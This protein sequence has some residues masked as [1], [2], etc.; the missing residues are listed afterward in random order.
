[1]CPG[2][3]VSISNKISKL[4]ETVKILQSKNLYLQE[5]NQRVKLINEGLSV[6]SPAPNVS[7]NVSPIT[8]NCSS[9]SSSETSARV[10]ILENENI[11]NKI[12]IVE[13]NFGNQLQLLK[14][15]FEKKLSDIENKP[16]QNFQPSHKTNQDLKVLSTKHDAL[17]NRMR[18]LENT[19][20]EDVR[21]KIDHYLEEKDLEDQQKPKNTFKIPFT[22]AQNQVPNLPHQTPLSLHRSFSDEFES[23]SSPDVSIIEVLHNKSEDVQPPGNQRKQDDYIHPSGILQTDFTKPPPGYSLF[24]AQFSEEL[25]SDETSNI[26]TNLDEETVIEANIGTSQSFLGK[27]LQR[28]SSL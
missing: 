20:E 13:L 19:F 10:V 23:C 1:M 2:T 6:N 28:H 7:S 3:N 11:T 22:P 25:L 24:P 18:K 17:N 8:T 16:K 5:E 14:L 15:E 26:E 4:E 12:N 21:K 9:S 27:D